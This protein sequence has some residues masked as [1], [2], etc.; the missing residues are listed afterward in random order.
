M[1]AGRNNLTRRAL[2]GAALAVPV[3]LGDCTDHAAAAAPDPAAARPWDR[4]L[5]APARPGWRPARLQPIRYC[6]PRIPRSRRLGY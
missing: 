1:A 4:A 3:V 5:A 6:V 2:L